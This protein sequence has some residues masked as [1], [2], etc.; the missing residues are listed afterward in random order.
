M[1]INS[2]LRESVEA[3][4]GGLEPMGPIPRLVIC[5][6]QHDPKHPQR[7][8]AEYIVIPHNGDG[9]RGQVAYDAR[10]PLR[11]S[12]RKIQNHPDGTYTE[13]IMLRRIEKYP[14]AARAKQSRR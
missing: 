10:W 3:S 8:R 11:V 4:A 6:I 1:G 2:D 7:E 5:K 12:D 13:K 9:V 14:K